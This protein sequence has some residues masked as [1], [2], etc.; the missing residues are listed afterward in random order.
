METQHARRSRLSVN[1]GKEAHT[2]LARSDQRPELLQ[3][4]LKLGMVMRPAPRADLR[5]ERRLFATNYAN[6]DRSVIF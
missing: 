3:K 6:S 2:V 5:P 4:S 1:L